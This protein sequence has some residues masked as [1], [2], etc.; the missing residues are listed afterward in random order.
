M[1]LNDDAIKIK[2]WSFDVIQLIEN[3]GNVNVL[4]RI[5]NVLNI[6]GGKN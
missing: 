4:A 5:F 1:N 2:I 3:A 6:F